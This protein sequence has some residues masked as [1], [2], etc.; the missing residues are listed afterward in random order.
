MPWCAR[1][2]KSILMIAHATACPMA[3]G[4]VWRRFIP[5]GDRTPAECV[6]QLMKNQI[7]RSPDEWLTRDNRQALSQSTHYRVVMARRCARS[8]WYP[9]G[10]A[11]ATKSFERVQAGPR[12]LGSLR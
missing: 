10:V 1:T 6:R 5:V 3:W 12:L 8:L 9:S 4:G 11:D 2:P 7:R